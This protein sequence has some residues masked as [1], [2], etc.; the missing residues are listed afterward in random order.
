M[1]DDLGAPPESWEVADL[2]ASM[3]RLMLSNSSNRDSTDTAFTSP[4]TATS[5]TAASVASAS[6]DLLNSVDQFLRDALQNPR[7]RVSGQFFFILL[8]E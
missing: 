8:C 7:E 3:T 6:E 5:A 4:A 2:D 1:V